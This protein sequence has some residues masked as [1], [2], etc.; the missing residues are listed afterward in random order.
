MVDSL[1]KHKKSSNQWFYFPLYQT[2]INVEQTAFKK[3][4]FRPN[5]IFYY[6]LLDMAEKNRP[7]YAF[8]FFLRLPLIVLKIIDK[9]SLFY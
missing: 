8:R 1:K 2:V 3:S 4:F 5:I 6:L 9:Q 7:K